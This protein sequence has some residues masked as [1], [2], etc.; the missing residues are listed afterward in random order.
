MR[1]MKLTVPAVVLLGGFLIC[2]SKVYGT[3]DYAKKEKKACTYCHTKMVA[4]KGEMSKNLNDTG[5]CYK[6]NDHSLAKCAPA[7]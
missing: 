5:N 2:T 1:L 4:D 7:K 3:A 6:G